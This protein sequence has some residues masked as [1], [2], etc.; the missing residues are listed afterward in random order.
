MDETPQFLWEAFW[1][2]I[3]KN[4]TKTFLKKY[5]T[6][7]Y[8][9]REKLHPNLGFKVSYSNNTGAKAQGSLF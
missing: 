4:M 7:G 2:E 6:K 9:A 1:L 3:P 8:I 5:H